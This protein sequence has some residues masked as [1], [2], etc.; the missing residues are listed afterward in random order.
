MLTA[1]SVHSSVAPCT[2]QSIASRDTALQC[3][4]KLIHS[5]HATW[6]G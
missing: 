1:A 5:K 2:P 6:S 4:A 3:T